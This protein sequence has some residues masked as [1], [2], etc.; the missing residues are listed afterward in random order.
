MTALRRNPLVPISQDPPLRIRKNA[1]GI[2]RPILYLR[3]TPDQI[4]EQ[5]SPAIAR[6]V[7]I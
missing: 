5:R 7:C 1:H 4:P 2:L 6:I 3:I